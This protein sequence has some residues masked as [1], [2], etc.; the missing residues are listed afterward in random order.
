MN[1][2]ELWKLF[3]LI[4]K[5]KS[6][7][8]VMFSWLEGKKTYLLAAATILGAIST[9]LAGAITFMQLVEAVMAALTAMSLRAGIT[10]SGIP[11]KKE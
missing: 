9:Y 4:L 8:S 11:P 10:K 6:K 7:E 2:K 1:I 3:K 5:L